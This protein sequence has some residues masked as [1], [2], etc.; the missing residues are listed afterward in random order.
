MNII[1]LLYLKNKTKWQKKAVKYKKT[2]KT[3]K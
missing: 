3:I 1:S 2:Q